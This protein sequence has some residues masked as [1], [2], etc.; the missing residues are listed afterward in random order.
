MFQEYQEAIEFYEKSLEM[1]EAY[2]IK[3][4]AER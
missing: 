2:R 1:F 4:R 3:K